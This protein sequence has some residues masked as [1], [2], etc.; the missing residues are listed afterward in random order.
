MLEWVWVLSILAGGIASYLAIAVFRS[1]KALAIAYSWTNVTFVAPAMFIGRGQ[2]VSALSMVAA[3]SL[4]AWWFGVLSRNDT[5]T[6]V[7]V[8]LVSAWLFYDVP[9]FSRGWLIAA[10]WVPLLANVYVLCRSDIDIPL[11]VLRSQLPRQADTWT[12]CADCGAACNAGDHYCA[13]CGS[14]I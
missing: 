11:F 3:A 13:T 1:G 12:L 4:V 8:G 14:E 5:L 6:R 2:S 10:W 7:C 9:G